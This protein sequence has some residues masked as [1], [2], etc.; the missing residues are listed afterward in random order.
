MVNMLPFQTTVK[1]LEFKLDT[2]SGKKCYIIGARELSITWHDDTRYW[3]WGHV[4]ESR[5]GVSASKVD[6]GLGGGRDKPLRPADVLLYLWDR[7]LDVCVN[8]TGSSPP[9]QIG[10]VDFVVGR[11]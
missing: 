5:P 3:K 8:L 2:N 1:T 6:I 10:M 7:G 11:A 9:T 4:P